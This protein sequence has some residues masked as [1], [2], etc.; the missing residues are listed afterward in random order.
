MARVLFGVQQFYSRK[1][2]VFMSFLLLGFLP[3]SSCYRLGLH[4][5]GTNPEY[6]TTLIVFASSPQLN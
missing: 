1:T 5:G 4:A 6:A 3:T 2:P